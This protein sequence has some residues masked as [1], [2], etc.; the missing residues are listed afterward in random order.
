MPVLR[1]SGMSGDLYIEVMV[2]TPSKLT[3]K[4]KELLRAFEKESEEG[5][6]PESESFLAKL[7][8]F[9][10]RNKTV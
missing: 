2:E 4:Q 5:M 8:E 3:R 9:W 1:G 10:G 6:F 7:K